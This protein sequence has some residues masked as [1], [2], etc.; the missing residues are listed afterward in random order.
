VHGPVIPLLSR[1]RDTGLL[2]QKLQHVVPAIPLLLHGLDRL[3][4]EPHAWSL[5]LGAAQVVVGVLVIGA[6]VRHARTARRGNEPHAAAPHGH[7][8][9]WVDLLI[10]AMLAVEVW[11]HWHETG[12]VKR[13]TVLLAVAMIA[14]GLAHGWIA[15][16]GQRRL[17]LRVDDAG[18][19]V[20]GPFFTR[21]T[22][23]WAQLAAVEIDPRQA[24][25]VRKD[26]RVRTIDLVDLR[27]A[28]EVREA[29]EGARLHVPPPAGDPAPV[30]DLP[31]GAIDSP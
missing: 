23:T 28:A 17:G 25:I 12:H 15:A 9:D 24:R 10:G 4:H 29:L 30:A 5:A 11:A 22:A 20:G 6:F 1:R 3:R 31:A 14:I 18:I 19:S 27:N 21:F 13:P 7:G 2:L 16:K 8:V 26:G